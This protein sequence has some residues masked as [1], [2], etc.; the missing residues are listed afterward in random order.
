MNLPN[1]FILY[2]VEWDAAQG[3]WQKIPC[4]YHGGN[5][6]PHDPSRW[7][8]YEAVASHATWD[9]SDPSKPYGVGWVLNGDGWFFLDLDKCR[10]E[11]GWSSEAAS[12]YQSFRGCLGEVSMSGTGLHIFGCCDPARLED[13]RNKWNSW[14]E[15]YT[16][17]RF[18]ALSKGGLA[19]IGDAFTG[20]DW[21]DQLLR[22][23]P[24]REH[25]GE[26]P[27]GRDPTYTGPEDDDA[28][29][30]MMLRSRGGASA[31]FGDTVTVKDLW[32]ANV[33]PLSKKWPAYDGG[34]GFDHSSA[35]AALMSHLAF[36]TGRD[37][38]RMD[39]LFRRSALMRDKYEKRAD[40][41]RDTIQ[42]AARLCKS[43]YDVPVAPA[44]AGTDTGAPD[45][46][47][48]AQE[49]IQHFDGCVY[50]RD[51]HRVLVPDGT[52]LK[53]E[54]FN[55]WYGG[56]LFPMTPDGSRPSKKAFEAFTENAVFKFPKASK[57]VFHPEHQFGVLVDDGVNIYVPAS[58]ESKPGDV[59]RFLDV[60][61]RILPFGNDLDILLSWGKWVVQNPGKKALWA[62]VLQGVEGNGK[63]TFFEAMA[64]AIGQQFVHRPRSKEI[65]S[66]FNS[67]Q[68]N[69]LL[70][71]V[72]EV[73]MEGRRAALD[74]LKPFITNYIVPIRDMHVTEAN[75]HCPTNWAFLTNHRD[76]V[77]K[78]KGDRRYCVMFTGQQT[79]EDLVRDFDGD[80]DSFW[81][82]FWHW[83]RDE[84]GMQA[85]AHYLMTSKP[86][87]RYS[88]EFR[89]R[90][91]E[92]TSTI[93][94]E[95]LS[96]GPIEH[97]ILDA[98]GSD[99]IGF[100]RGWVSSWHLQ[101]LMDEKRHKVSGPRL[102]EIMRSL[103]Y[104]NIGR[105]PRRIP[106]E[107]GVRPNLWRVNGS[108]A[109]FEDYI[110]AQYFDGS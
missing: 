99:R 2:R 13:R 106:A 109:T 83:M 74:D 28:L 93:D 26:L 18:V 97:D 5:I 29:I 79:K 31:A 52:L 87:D 43:V 84:G 45:Y 57:S 14:L 66:T 82:D 98:C 33:E 17:G 67:W 69:K 42:N 65:G 47:L 22:F 27:D 59:S 6:N 78:S 9:T 92:T 56:H 1:R 61:R 75:R 37:L 49:M 64:Y 46:V 94:A 10:T 72:E 100:R 96:L 19:P 80:P 15:F 11:T 85:V 71:I 35:D 3:K 95:A 81:R 24:Q 77:I 73:H 54:Q 40:Y 21:T 25:L 102:G 107:G 48:T 68:V 58:V 104:E 63:S 32:E 90:A 39:R 23:V 44:P 105:T 51:M 103:G 16:T 4:D 76:A 62:P 89:V 36:W 108:D 7:Q 38:P 34:G 50:V 60:M 20:Q 41:R 91:P 53:P 101:R 70:I 30:A 55:A 8:T 12:I 88:P 86:D 110:G